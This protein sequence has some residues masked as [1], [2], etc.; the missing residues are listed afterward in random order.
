MIVLL[1][2]GRKQYQVVIPDTASTPRVIFYTPT[3]Q[4]FVLKYTTVCYVYV[5]VPFQVTDEDM[6]LTFY[7]D[8]QRNCEVANENKRSDHKN[9]G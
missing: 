9:T 4:C 8:G 7:G 3:K 5:P 2:D 6:S 1:Q